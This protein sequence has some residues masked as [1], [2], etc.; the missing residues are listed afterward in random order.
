MTTQVTRLAGFVVLTFT[1]L[2]AGCDSGHKAANG[3]PDS[4]QGLVIASTSNPGPGD[5]VVRDGADADIYF[6]STGAEVTANWSIRGNLGSGPANSPQPSAAGS[7]T[8]NGNSRG[9]GSP[10][11]TGAASGDYQWA[12][13][14]AP[15]LADLVPLTSAG[16]NTSATAR[17]LRLPHGAQVFVSVFAVDAGGQLLMVALSDGVEVDLRSP[18]AGTVNDGTG[19]RRSTPRQNQTDFSANLYGFSDLGSGIQALR[20]VDRDVPRC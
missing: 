4:S 7:A 13:G 1:L 18:L 8:L 12:A 10:I 11:E 14:S 9:G 17:G 15:G 16:Q 3:S 6:Q 19:Y 5:L 2:A 20:V